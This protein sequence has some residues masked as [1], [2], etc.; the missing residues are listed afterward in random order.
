MKEDIIKLDIGKKDTEM[1]MEVNWFW[2][3]FQE[4]CNNCAGRSS[5]LKITN[6]L[7]R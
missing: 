1:S 2:I 6:L 3:E 7:P 4:F 5:S